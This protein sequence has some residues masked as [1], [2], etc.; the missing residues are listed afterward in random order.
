M[1]PAGPRIKRLKMKVVAIS[2]CNPSGIVRAQMCTQASAMEA[3]AQADGFL[4]AEGFFTQ[5]DEEFAAES[6][7]W[8][9]AGMMPLAAYSRPSSRNA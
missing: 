7:G 4:D 9:D 6:A 5:S 1:G 2:N 3:R 8:R